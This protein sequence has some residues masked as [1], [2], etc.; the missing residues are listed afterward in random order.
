MVSSCLSF[1]KMAISITTDVASM[2]RDLKSVKLDLEFMQERCT[3]LEEENAKLRDGLAKD[4]DDLVCN[5]S[6]NLWTPFNPMLYLNVPTCV[7][8]AS[9]RGTSGR[10][11]EIGK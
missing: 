2:A 1:F 5:N 4:E 11:V 10:K 7:G 9:I 8:E 6:A 3:L